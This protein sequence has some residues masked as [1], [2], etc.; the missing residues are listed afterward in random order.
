MERSILVTGGAGYIGSHTAKML[1]QRGYLPVVLDNLSSGNEWAVKW[2]P[3]VVGD[4]KDAACVRNT[5]KKFDIQAVIHLAASAYVGESMSQPAQYFENNV[6]NSLA[7]L[8]ALLDC[9]GLPVVFSSTCATFGTPEKLPITTDTP[10][11]PENPYGESKLFIEKTLSWYARA[12]NFRSVILRY[13]NA[14]GADPDGEIGE[15]HEPE[16]HL[17]PLIMEVALGLRESIKIFGT[18][19]PTP[20]GT[21]VRDFVHVADL[22]DAHIRAVQYLLKGGPSVSLNLGTGKGYSVREAIH[23]VERVSGERVKTVTRPRRAGDPAALVA[24]AAAAHRTLG[25]EP[26]FRDLDTIIKT[27]WRWH[28]AIDSRTRAATA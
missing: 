1:S 18:D 19:Y 23:I 13:F 2:G 17:L 9:G 27:A 8:K 3:L 28:N 22:A 24:C 11:A 15:C 14:A 10:Q 20:D 12:Y 25:W 5:V 26:Q 4:I 7:L 21:A 6:T 16:T